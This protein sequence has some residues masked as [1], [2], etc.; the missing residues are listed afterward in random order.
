MIPDRQA[1]IQTLMI[2]DDADTVFL[3]SLKLDEACGEQARF[4]VES[5][6]TLAEGIAALDKREFDVVLLDLMLPDSQG[7]ET[8]ARLRAAARDIPIVVLTGLADE[9]LGLDA[10]AH[11]AQ[12]FISKD[13]I[14]ARLLRRAIGYAMERC[15]L[16]RENEA[17]LESTDNGLIVV[18]GGVVR[19]ANAA[20]ERLLDRPRSR[21]LGLPYEDPRG[22]EARGELK[23]EGRGGTR[24]L[25]LRSTNMVW[26]K[27][28]ATLVSLVDV[29]AA[30]GLEQ[31]RAEV[32][33][34]RKSEEFKDR[35]VSAVSHELRSPLTIAKAALANLVDGLAGQLSGDQ[36]SMADIA[37][38]NVDR[39]TRLVSNFLEFSRLESGRAKVRLR[40]IEPGTT[41]LQILADWRI[42][43]RR[44]NVVVEPRISAD[45]PRVWADPDLVAQVVCNLLDNA[46]R[47]AGS[48]IVISAE[49]HAEGILISVSDDGPGIPRE[50]VGELFQPFVQLAR[51][52]EGYK[53]TGLG[54]S[55]CRQA[56]ELCGGRIWIDADASPGA[57]VRFTLPESKP[58]E[59]AEAADEKSPGR[60]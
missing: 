54:L 12:D 31:I 45:L 57:A 38:R 30:R 7:L 2:E 32:R 44:P 52:G 47:F 3:M 55:I 51:V 23:V 40:R 59:K 49:P 5:A 15:A 42:A 1:R 11:G 6:G 9:R 48:K 22:P 43:E 24:Y 8:V 41:L 36:Q 35:V 50:R 29:T 25:E 60:R 14:D 20:A 27:Q 13:A 53:G 4:T 56:V 18:V 46:C 19:F 39:L 33:E 21:M 34:R 10:I 28:K 26:R 37:L 17:V 16:H 58:K